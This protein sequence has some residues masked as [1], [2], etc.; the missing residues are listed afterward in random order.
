MIR[1]DYI[2]KG[3]GIAVVSPSYHLDDGEFAASL[4]AVRS[5]GFVP[6]PAPGAE[7]IHEG[8]Y[9][10]TPESRARQLEWAF[11]NPDAAAVMASRG[12]YGAIQLLGSLPAHMFEDNPKWMLGYS[13]ITCLHSASV[14]CGVMSLH[15][16][17]GSSLAAASDAE[18]VRLTCG[19]LCG[20]V[21]EYQWTSELECRSGAAEGVLLG[22]NL[23]TLTPLVGT[24]YDMFSGF[25]DIVLFIEDIGEPA[26]NIDRM[27]N[28]LAL[29]G[30]MKRVRG[31]VLGEF[32]DCADEFGFGSVERMLLSVTAGLGVPL[33]CSFP[34]GHGSRNYPL[35]EG[36]RVRLEIDA[37]SAGL[38][39][40]D[41]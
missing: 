15:S 18:S 36:S 13:D 31:I 28:S 4:E 6:L 2:S 1:P 41:L 33:A 10:G 16:L 39:F 23:A 20:T 8:L 35:V 32:T 38:R 26:R 9:A 40:L 24:A 25:G 34:A 12:G 21:P 3:D 19:L 17:M 5:M 11:S 7:D 27:M 37:H 30:V 14:A 22:G 29:H